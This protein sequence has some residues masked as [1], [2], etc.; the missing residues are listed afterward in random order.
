MATLS[1]PCSRGLRK[2]YTFRA[3]P[4]Q[5]GKSVMAQAKNVLPG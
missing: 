2:L 3:E 5:P 4:V 1:L